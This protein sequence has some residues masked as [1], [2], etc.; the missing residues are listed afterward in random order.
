MVQDGENGDSTENK[1][2]RNSGQEQQ[3]EFNLEQVQSTEADQN[4]KYVLHVP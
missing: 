2:P 3:L 4:K 1:D